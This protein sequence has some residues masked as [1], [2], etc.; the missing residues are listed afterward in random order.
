M[1]IKFVTLNM[2]LGGI[3]FDNIIAFLKDQDADIVVL[4][5][6]F[7]GEDK[8]LAAQY[9][10]MQVLKEQLGYPY[11][12]FVAD[13]RDFDYTDGKAQRGNAIL[14]KF[15]ITSGDAV[16]FDEPYTEEYRNIRVNFPNCP[17]NLQHV[18][19]DTPAGE[20]NIY[21]IQGV[22][23]MA[24]AS[25]STKRK[26]MSEA[27][28]K[29]IDG[30]QNTILAG[31]VNARPVN[32]AVKNIEEHLKSVFGNELASTF[33]MRRKDDPGYASAAVDMILVSPNIKVLERNCP[34]IDVSDHLP[35]TA[36]LVI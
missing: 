19:L 6:V 5:E 17:R 32:Q 8:S 24:G 30:K 1:K 28:I 3:L 22:W 4:Q 21:N 7:N 26:L 36:T 9:R 10:S 14:S 2:W 12:D 18:S 13:Y 11:D 15:L 23:D 20:V 34:D 27:V 35:L 25:Y 16:F 31:D 33:N 29:A